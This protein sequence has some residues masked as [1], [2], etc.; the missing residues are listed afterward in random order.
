MLQAYGVQRIVSSPATRCAQTVEPYS[1]S[2]STF[3]EIDDR[4]SEQT[5][6]SQV[7]RSVDTLMDRKKPVA[8]CSHR[9]TLPSIFDAIG[10]AVADLAPGDGVVVHHRGGVIEAT[11][12]LT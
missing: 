7:Q 6:T 5:R 8:L 1:R 10:L 9:P 4:L 11:E 12:R 3:L 2:V